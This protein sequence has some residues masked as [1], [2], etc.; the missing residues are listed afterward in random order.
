[1]NQDAQSLLVVLV[2]AAVTRIAADGSYQLYVRG[3]LRPWLLIAGIVLIV[4]GIVSLLR[5]DLR[6]RGN[7]A[8]EHADDGVAADGDG[9]GHAHTGQRWVAWLL[10]APILVIFLV[11]PPALG[12]YTAAHRGGGVA[13]PVGDST[14]TALPAG[15]AVPDTLRDFSERAVW[16]KGRTLTGRTVALTG[17]VT[18]RTGG[19]IFLTRMMITC[20][21]ADASPI[22]VMVTGT[23]P[24]VRA[25]EWLKVT[26]RYAGLDHRDDNGSGPLAVLRVV[27]I[28]PVGA[29]AEPYE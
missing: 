17:F 25:N 1:M 24:R 16:D 10:L 11:A 20:C 8:V 18:P 6:R 21:A 26:G 13:K 12:A 7:D 28:T 14:F 23:I 29:P 2:G 27:R 3:N 15:S 5:S 22:E 19:G 9:H 4:I